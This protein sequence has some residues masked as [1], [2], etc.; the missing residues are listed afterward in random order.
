M[1]AK[2]LK[3]KIWT[4]TV[5]QNDPDAKE[6]GIR[7]D[8]VTDYRDPDRILVL[9]GARVYS[10]DTAFNIHDRSA[11]VE[12][13]WDEHDSYLMWNARTEHHRESETYNLGRNPP[14]IFKDAFLNG[15]VLYG[16]IIARD[17][18]QHG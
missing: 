14:Q 10:R 9:D 15:L 17:E 13:R 3:Y 12:P 11:A 6:R 16:V 1:A 5:R 18:Q 2:E 7:Q 4:D 8:G